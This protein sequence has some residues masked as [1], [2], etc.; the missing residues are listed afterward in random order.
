MSGEVGAPCPA[1][2]TEEDILRCLFQNCNAKYNTGQVKAQDLLCTLKVNC[3]FFS[4]FHPL[5][6][7]VT[8]P[9][10]CSQN[11]LDK[12]G[13]LDQTSLDELTRLIDPRQ[14]N[15]YLFIDD[16]VKLGLKWISSVRLKSPEPSDLM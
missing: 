2:M 13:I 6:V 1:T 15:S 10:L 11:T 8:M 14:D 4:H 7:C 12:D 3:G 9:S 16:F 5:N